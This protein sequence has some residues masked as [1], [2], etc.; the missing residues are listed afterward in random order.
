MRA[1]ANEWL[2]NEWRQR[3]RSVPQSRYWRRKPLVFSQVP[4]CHGLC[5]S[6]NY[7]AM[8][9]RAGWMWRLTSELLSRQS[10][11]TWNNS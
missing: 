9:V 11:T 3:T 7:T 6:Q 10:G 5:G 4:R 1:P 2:V 8:P